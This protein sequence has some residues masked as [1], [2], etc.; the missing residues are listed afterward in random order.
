MVPLDSNKIPT[1][2]RERT[3]E[4]EVIRGFLHIG[5]AEHTGVNPSSR[6]NDHYIYCSA[7]CGQLDIKWS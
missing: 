1:S 6:F 2:G 7:F 3:L 5:I 4:K